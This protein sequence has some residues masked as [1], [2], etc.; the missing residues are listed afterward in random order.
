MTYPLYDGLRLGLAGFRRASGGKAY[1]LGGVDPRTSPP[2]SRF[3]SGAYPPLR[4]RPT[5]RATLLSDGYHL[6]VPREGSL[7]AGPG[8]CRG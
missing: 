2:R 8:I 7:L 4:E 1:A 5:A 3:P 6:E